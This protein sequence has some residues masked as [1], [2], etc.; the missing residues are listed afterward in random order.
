MKLFQVLFVCTGN[1]CR[2]PMAEALLRTKLGKTQAAGSL[3]VSSAGISAWGGQPASPEAVSAM[4][5]RG[6]SSIVSHRS[7]QVT[8]A[9]IASSD[10]I[11]TMTRFHQEKLQK[12]FADQADKIFLLSEYAGAAEDVVDPAGGS[13]YEYQMC[14]DE[15]DHL[16]EAALR[17]ILASAGTE[18]ANSEK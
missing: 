16:V 3:N 10:L 4:A 14:A 7:Q 2:S 8:A 15:L 11:L 12:C 17:R 5:E 18:R 1:T 6:I 9:Q 13:L